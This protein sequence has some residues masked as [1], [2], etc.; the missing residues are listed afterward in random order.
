[1]AD[2]TP[3]PAGLALKEWVL[4]LFLDGHT[5]EVRG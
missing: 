1:M 3:I 4:P 2:W 5:E